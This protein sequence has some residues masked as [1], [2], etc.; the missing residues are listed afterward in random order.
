MPIIHLSQKDINKSKACDAGWALFQL[1]S[2]EEKASKDKNSVNY[3]FEF[4]CVNAQNS[5]NIGRYVYNMVN[6]KAPGIGMIPMVSALLNIPIDQVTAGD[7]DS[8]KLLSK[9][10]WI[11][12]IDEVY[13]GKIQKRCSAFA[14]EISRVPF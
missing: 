7:V 5:D 9:K 8:D 6:S 3:T 14:A 4:E 11:E 10:C 1:L 12:V 2:V 13:E